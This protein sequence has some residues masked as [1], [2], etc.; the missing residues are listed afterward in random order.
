MLNKLELQVA[1][2]QESIDIDLAEEFAKEANFILKLQKQRVHNPQGTPHTADNATPIWY[3]CTSRGWEWT[4]D[5]FNWMPA[6]TT[7][8]QNGPY[9]GQRPVHQN[10]AIIQ[11]L[12]KHGI[13][14]YY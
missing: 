4:P 10:I 14:Q 9:R 5:Q 2:L 3:R 8:V 1:K 11:Y 12:H 6:S 7:V 13:S